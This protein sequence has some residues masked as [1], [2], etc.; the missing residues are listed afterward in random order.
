MEWAVLPERVYEVDW[1]LLLDLSWDML[2][3]ILDIKNYG[4]DL[5]VC[6]TTELMSINAETALIWT[7]VV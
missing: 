5:Y 1:L 6:S 3:D 4:K 7:H 2:D